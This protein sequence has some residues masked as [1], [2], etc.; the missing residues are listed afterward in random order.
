MMGRIVPLLY[1]QLHIGLLDAICPVAA[2]ILNIKLIMGR[3]VLLR[4][5]RRTAAR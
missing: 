1:D 5:A 4:S 2:H 3:I